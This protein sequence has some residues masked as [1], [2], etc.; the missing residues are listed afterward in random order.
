MDM[1]Q[2][3]LLVAEAYLLAVRLVDGRWAYFDG[4]VNSWFA[5]EEEDMES[6]GQML[7]E[8]SIVYRLWGRRTRAQKLSDSREAHRRYASMYG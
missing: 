1:R 7:T 3:W 5:V 2:Y 8:Q 6:L 4:E